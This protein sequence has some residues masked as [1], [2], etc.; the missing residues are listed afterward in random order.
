VDETA[1]YATYSKTPFPVFH[2]HLT[3]DVTAFHIF[4]LHSPHCL[5]SETYLPFPVVTLNNILEIRLS[6]YW[7]IR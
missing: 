5:N 1:L 6:G 3:L 2:T 7:T 4:Q